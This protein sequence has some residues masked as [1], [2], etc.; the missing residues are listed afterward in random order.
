MEEGN[1]DN[2][3][4]GPQI[5]LSQA[6]LVRI[7]YKMTFLCLISPH[8]ALYARYPYEFLSLIFDFLN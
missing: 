3:G 6:L 8:W 2:I 7:I 5:A 4:F 1:V